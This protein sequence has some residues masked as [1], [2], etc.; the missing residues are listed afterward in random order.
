MEVPSIIGTGVQGSG[1]LLDQEGARGWGLGARGIK[2]NSSPLVWFHS[3]VF[4]NMDKEK[5]F[6]SRHIV[7]AIRHPYTN[8][9]L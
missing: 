8:P 4:L 5:R 9:L 6:M 7:R 3:C 1:S 2:K